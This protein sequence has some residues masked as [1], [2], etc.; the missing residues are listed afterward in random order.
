MAIA[1]SVETWGI[2]DYLICLNSPDRE[3]WMKTPWKTKGLLVESTI[4]IQW[5]NV[6]TTEDMI[7]LNLLR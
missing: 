7:F 3:M 2:S 6:C 5:Q 1:S 4:F